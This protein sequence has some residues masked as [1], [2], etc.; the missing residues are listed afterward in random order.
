ME[1]LKFIRSLEEL[2]YEVMTWLLFYPRTLWRVLRHPMA[3][4]GQAEA[5]MSG[6][7]DEQFIDLVSPPLFLML[8]FLLAHVLELAMHIKLQGYDTELARS[9]L[10]SDTNLL[11]F[12]IVVGSMFPLLMASGLLRRQKRV[13]DRKTLRR[14]FYLQCFFAAPFFMC[15][16]GAAVIGRHYL[17]W[18]GFALG[19]LGTAWY[20]G[21]QTQWF[22]TR[23]GVGRLRALGIACW[24]FL[25]GAAFAV[26]ISWL[27]FAPKPE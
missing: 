18:A 20:L 16:S 4:A 5:E 24:L 13:I 17:P 21:V 3:L 19:V 9:V 25:L 27:I 23:L 7:D 6:A 8:T 15:F 1:F 14:P 11:I 2:L 22:H 10:A 12:R 26:G